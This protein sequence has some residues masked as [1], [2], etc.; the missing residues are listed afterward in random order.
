MG[1][2]TVKHYLNTNL[3]P[4][5][6]N[7]EQYFSIYALVTANRQNTKVKS[8][9]F[10]EY[11][12]ENDF[13]ELLN[14]KNKEDLKLIQD[15]ERAIINITSL[16]FNV[17]DVFDTSLFAAIYNYYQSIYI[18]DIDIQL[19]KIRIGE[20][21]TIVDL[22][23][24]SKNILGIDISTFFIS[25]FSLKEN[26]SKGMS[27]FTWF[28]PI[29]Q[30]ELKRFLEKSNCNSEAIETLNKIVFFKSFEKLKWIFKGSKKLETLIDKY[31]NLFEM[32]ETQLEPLYK[33][34]SV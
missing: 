4:Y 1:K 6:I 20:K 14:P 5:L 27:L 29:G 15:E 19:F 32:P 12:T 21:E 7:G 13:N 11:Y 34:L 3:K 33:K 31:S 25:E 10:N 30:T 9:V 8:K 28:S 18:F 16:I 26:N 2:I 23:N 22:Y 24:E 17:T